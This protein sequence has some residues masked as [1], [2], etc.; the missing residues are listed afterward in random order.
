MSRFTKRAIVGAAVAGLVASLTAF[1][2]VPGA[3]AQ[4]QPGDGAV[5]I[6]VLSA[7][8]VSSASPPVRS[9]PPAP[10]ARV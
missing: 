10:P 6:T 5:P 4:D 7:P 8:P 2:G 3:G 9:P 1:A